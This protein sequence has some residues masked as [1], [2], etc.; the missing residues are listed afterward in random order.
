MN[1]QKAEAIGDFIKNAFKNSAHTVIPNISAEK[2]I[3]HIVTH[4][5]GTF[6]LF[7]AIDDRPNVNIMV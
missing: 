5:D 4:F 1:L 6:Y 7:F 2:G 3:W